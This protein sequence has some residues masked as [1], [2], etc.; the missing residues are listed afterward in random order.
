M[1]VGFTPDGRSLISA[2]R[3]QQDPTVSIWSNG[4]EVRRIDGWAPS[5]ASTVSDSP[6][7]SS[8]VTATG[9]ARPVLSGD[10]R[11]LALRGVD[12]RLRIVDTAT[13]KDAANLGTAWKAT[14]HAAF[15]PGGKELLIY[16]GGGISTKKKKGGGGP[17]GPAAPPPN[18]NQ[19]LVQPG[20]QPAKP[21]GKADP[22]DKPAPADGQPAQPGAQPGQPGKGKGG[23]KKATETQA[24]LRIVDL[25][26][27]KEVREVGVHPQ[28][29][30]RL[31]SSGTFALAGTKGEIRLIDLATGRDVRS[32]GGIPKPPEDPDGPRR[33]AV[34]APVFLL[35]PDGRSVAM[36]NTAD[37]SVRLWELASNQERTVFKGHQ[38]PITCMDFSPD[39]R[40][41]VTGSQDGTILVW[42]VGVSAARRKA[43][44]KGD[45]LDKL[46]ADL[47]SP[48][49][50]RAFAAVQ[51]LADFPAE[52]ADLI[53]ARLQATARVKD[54][55]IAAK[56]SDLDS[57]THAVRQKAEDDLKKLGDQAEA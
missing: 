32:V 9:L 7:A 39:G 37:N 55:V 22:K 34:K 25:Q 43:A 35:S 54:D 29:I 20:D 46:W 52:A 4:R 47:A 15:L 26:T 2:G 19:A 40:Y 36:L 6:F 33:T 42:A 51:T 57:P 21:G 31:V 41:F 16:D 5:T 53:K 13:G 3:D 10:G 12:G 27:G 50:P 30:T 49:A 28:A 56:I 23:F 44:P 8:R 17:A 48:Q 45:D 38:G 11:L 24:A 1:L 14:S 18:P